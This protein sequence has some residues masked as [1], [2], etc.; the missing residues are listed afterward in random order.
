MRERMS[1]NQSSASRHL[2]S[3]CSRTEAGCGDALGYYPRNFT[4]PCFV[5]RSRN[6][7]AI[8]SPLAT[9]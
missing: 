3:A 2:W 9:H 4:S 1:R 5:R 6:A 7:S 8:T